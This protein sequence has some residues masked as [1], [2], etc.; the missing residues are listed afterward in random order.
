MT[1]VIITK[2]RSF[3][4]WTFNEFKTQFSLIAD[5][6]GSPKKFEICST[7]VG[8]EIET[9]DVVKKMIKISKICSNT[10]TRNNTCRLL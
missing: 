8:Q 7:D 10:L 2:Q 4:S 9:I 3:S 5:F 6:Y 1:I